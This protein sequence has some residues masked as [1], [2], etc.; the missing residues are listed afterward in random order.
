MKEVTIFVTL[1]D[2]EAW[3]YAQFLKRV[4]FSDY[5]QRAT[6][7]PEAYRMVDAGEK[8]RDALREEGYVPR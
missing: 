7:E 4:C 2:S 6:S 3:Q 8:I 1:T 5:R